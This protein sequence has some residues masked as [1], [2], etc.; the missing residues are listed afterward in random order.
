LLEAAASGSDLK[1]MDPERVDDLDCIVLAGQVYEG[2]EAYPI[3]FWLAEQR[4]FLPVKIE[5]EYPEYA[6]EVVGKFTYSEPK[7]RT[8]LLSEAHSFFIGVGKPVR[9]DVFLRDPDFRVNEGPHP[10][11][12]TVSSLMADETIWDHPW[13]RKIQAARSDDDGPSDR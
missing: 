2:E 3:R 8:W 13:I 11:L 5:L 4:K 9:E 7:P 10:D 1:I 12:E 6:M